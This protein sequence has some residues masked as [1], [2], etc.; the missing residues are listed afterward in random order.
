MRAKVLLDYTE[1]LQEVVMLRDKISRSGDF[2]I[3]VPEQLKTDP[4]MYLSRQYDFAPRGKEVENLIRKWMEVWRT[5]QS[6]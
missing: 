2:Y 4:F 6:G 3:E 1:S 5:R